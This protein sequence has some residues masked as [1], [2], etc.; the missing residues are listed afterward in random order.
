MIYYTYSASSNVVVNQF[1]QLSPDTNTVENHTTGKVL[2]LCRSV[3][4]SEDD[5][6]RYAEVY[7]AGGGGQ[8][9]ILGTDWN[10]SPTRFDVIDSKV[11]PVSQGGLGWIIPE[12]PRE[13]KH[14][15]SLVNIAI[16]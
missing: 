1:V 7:V 3:Y 14:S 2:G 8:P 4:V 12:L 9:A 15:N 6:I 10:G 11:V 13:T 16:Y 5:S